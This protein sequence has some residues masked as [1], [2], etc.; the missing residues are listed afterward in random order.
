M[1]LRSELRSLTLAPD[2]APRPQ[3]PFGRGP[4]AARILAKVIDG[5]AWAG[6]HVPAPVTHA[7]AVAGGHAEW[8]LR[9][10]KR[11]ALA[12][13]LAHAVGLLPDDRQVRRSVRR[14][15]VNEAR[16]SADL[17]WALGR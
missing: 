6:S 3:A 4:V 7:L 13:N 10:G 12:T 16:R 17:L 5:S 1:G 9:P 14:E 15:I 8:A 2:G 11:Q